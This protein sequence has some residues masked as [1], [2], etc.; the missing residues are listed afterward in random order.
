MPRINICYFKKII[1][2]NKNLYKDFFANLGEIEKNFTSDT[3]I[4][5]ETEIKNE[6]KK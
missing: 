5:N 1:L 3:K 4:K 2:I 6:E